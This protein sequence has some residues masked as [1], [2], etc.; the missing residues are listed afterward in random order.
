MKKRILKW[1]IIAA[2]A[3]I[4]TLLSVF[5]HTPLG[6]SYI[7]TDRTPKFIDVAPIVKV[8]NGMIF[9]RDN[10]LKWFLKGYCE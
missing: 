7:A 10:D 1:N 4:F 6:I 8:E 2:I 9:I 3:I 5:F